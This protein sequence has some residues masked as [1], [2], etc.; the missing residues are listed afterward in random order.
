M[1]LFVAAEIPELH[2]ASLASALEPLKHLLSAPR[3]TSPGSWHVTLKF[4]G[5]VPELHLDEVGETL[6]DVVTKGEPFQ[7][8]MTE[9]GAFP[10]SRRPRV[11]WM[12]LADEENAFRNLA[13][14][15]DRKFERAG[16]PAGGR[17]FRPH[18]TLA[19]FKVDRQERGQTLPSRSGPVSV[20]RFLQELSGGNIERS[21]FGITELV[22]FR[23]NLARV[24]AVYEPLMRFGF[25]ASA[26][27]GE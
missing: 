5:E 12:G 18:V 4:L 9:P 27:S 19:R 3:W 7:T 21:A 23:S 1:R 20:R 11:L 13:G 10:N 8:R 22:L 17:P 15:M 24:G 25:R 6:E 26:G 2:R 16:F 14:R